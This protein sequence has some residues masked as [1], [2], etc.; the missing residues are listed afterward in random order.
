MKEQKGDS[1]VST[2]ILKQS[3][4]KIFGYSTA[5]SIF[6]YHPSDWDSN[7]S[8]SDLTDNEI[9]NPFGTSQKPDPGLIETVQKAF[10]IISEN[11]YTISQASNW[12]LEEE[13]EGSRNQHSHVNKR[14]LTSL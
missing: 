1:D 4:Y 10:R 11:S 9:K 5:E 3:V 2:E 6:N 12:F 14:G 13:S 8:E 7:H